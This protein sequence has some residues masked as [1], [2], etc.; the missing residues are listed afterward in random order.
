MDASCHVEGVN[1]QPRE[2]VDATWTPRGQ[3]VSLKHKHKKQHHINIDR[4]NVVPGDVII[5]IITSN[6]VSTEFVL[7]KTTT[8]DGE[9]K[10]N[11]GEGKDNEIVP[12]G[13]REGS[14]L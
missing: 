1:F 6:N 11:Y 5:I 3:P 4:G 13:A 14:L 2:D 9:G 12:G 8:Y 10:D 7:T